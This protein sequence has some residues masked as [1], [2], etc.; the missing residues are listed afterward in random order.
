MFASL[1]KKENPIDKSKGMN[2]LIRVKLNI[3]QDIKIIS[4]IKCK[5]QVAETYPNYQLFHGEWGK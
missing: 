3:H 2:L 5:W 4:H 1:S